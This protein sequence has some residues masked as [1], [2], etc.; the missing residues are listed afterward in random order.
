VKGLVSDSSTEN[1]YAPSMLITLFIGTF[2][3]KWSKSLRASPA[4][5]VRT[6]NATNHQWRK[7]QAKRTHPKADDPRNRQDSKATSRTAL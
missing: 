5:G 3:Q 6:G 4:T 7:P 2:W 1:V